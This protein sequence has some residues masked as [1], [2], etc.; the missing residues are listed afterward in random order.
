MWRECRHKRFLR[1]EFG[2]YHISKNQRYM[3]NGICLKVWHYSQIIQVSCL[4]RTKEIFVWTTST[5]NKRHIQHAHE[6]P[7]KGI[8]LILGLFYSD[9][10]SLYQLLLYTFPLLLGSN[11]I[12]WRDYLAHS[13]L[14]NQTNVCGTILIS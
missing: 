6:S 9:Y 12:L 13:F 1:N 7:L 3:Y 2:F 14:L 8:W 5:Q 11:R 4:R 10:T